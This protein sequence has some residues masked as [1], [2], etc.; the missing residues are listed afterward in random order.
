[1]R[2]VD[3]EI[4]WLNFNYRCLHMAMRDSIPFLERLNFLGITYSNMSE[5][6]AVR[7]SSVIEGFLSSNKVVDDLGNSNFDKKYEKLLPAIMKFKEKQYSVYSDL[8]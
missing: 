5:F 2:A 3:R 4:S 8:K 7:F 6:V 1:M